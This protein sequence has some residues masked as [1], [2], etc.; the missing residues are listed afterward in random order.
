MMRS[1]EKVKNVELGITLTYGSSQSK[2][3]DNNR[4]EEKVQ[5]FTSRGLRLNS[6]SIQSYYFLVWCFFKLV[7]IT[8]VF[9]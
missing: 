8:T 7:S 6:T 3:K 4:S 5:V 1:A 9:L 2:D